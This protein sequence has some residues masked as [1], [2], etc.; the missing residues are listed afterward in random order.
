MSKIQKV[1]DLKAKLQQEL[2]EFGK[3]AFA[4]AAEKVFSEH[5]DI[6]GITF[7]AFESYF[8]DGDPTS[9]QV[10]E[11]YFVTESSLAEAQDEYGDKVEFHYIKPWFFDGSLTSTYFRS[12]WKEKNEEYAAKGYDWAKEFRP[13]SQSIKEFQSCCDTD[14]VYAVFGDHVQVHIYKNKEGEVVV[15]SDYLDHD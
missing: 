12:D 13:E 7:S 14:I 1:L 5:S 15:S 11:I 3:E 4:E 2:S 8:N 6:I 10:R 9:Y